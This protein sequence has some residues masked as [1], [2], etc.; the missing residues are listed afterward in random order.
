MRLVGF[1]VHKKGLCA[2]LY[3]G[4]QR[5]EGLKNDELDGSCAECFEVGELSMKLF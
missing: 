2:G 3:E 1:L 4:E 5:E